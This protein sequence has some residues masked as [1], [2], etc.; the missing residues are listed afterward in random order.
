MINKGSDEGSSTKS[1]AAGTETDLMLIYSDREWIVDTCAS[2]H[3]ASSLQMLKAYRLV[4]KSDRSKVHLPTGGV[5]SVTHTGLAFVFKNQDIFN[6]LYIPEFKFNLLLVSKLTK[7]LKCLN[8]VAEKK[9]I[10]IFEIAR[11]LRFQAGIP[12]RFW[13]ECVNTDVYLLNRLPSRVINVKSPFE[14]LYLHAPSLSHLKVFGFLCYADMCMDKFASKAIPEHVL[15]LHSA[16]YKLK[17]FREAVSDS[18]WVQ[19]MKQEVVALEDNNT[20][21]IV[22]FPP[23]KAPIGCKW[24]FKVKYRASGEIERYKP[25]LVPK[26]IQSEK[27]SRLH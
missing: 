22:D 14:M 24:I 6:A 1:V 7:E 23:D 8:G 17:T 16:V 18:K 19:E 9:H 12:L 3:M 21:A 2:N 25:E 15:A 11:A 10:T 27:G 4:P 20:W 5:V 13:G 26:R